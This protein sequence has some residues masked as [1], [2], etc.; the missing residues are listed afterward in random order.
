[1]WDFPGGP[2]VKNSPSNAWSVVSIP[3]QG[4]KIPHVMHSDQNFKT[5]KQTKKAITF[6]ISVSPSL[7]SDPHPRHQEH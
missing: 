5:N 1:M 7:K 3:V 6:L 2:E 4:T